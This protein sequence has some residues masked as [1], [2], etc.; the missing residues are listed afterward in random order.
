MC[1]I[2]FFG[3]FSVSFSLCSEVYQYMIYYIIYIFIYIYKSKF[4]ISVTYIGRSITK[5]TSSELFAS[6]WQAVCPVQR[7]RAD[8]PAN[9]IKSVSI[10]GM[11]TRYEI[12]CSY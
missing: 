8:V 2:Y 7:A 3:Y 9:R 6:Q 4:S 12:D 10:A 5:K 11:I 1:A